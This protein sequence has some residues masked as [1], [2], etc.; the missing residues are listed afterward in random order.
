[1]EY[2]SVYHDKDACKNVIQER[3]EHT[4]MVIKKRKLISIAN[5]I[6]D[7]SDIKRSA[8]KLLKAF[9]IDASK[10]YVPIVEILN[11][12]GIKVYK[13]EMTDKQLS[14]YISVDPEYYDEYG[15]AKIACVNSNDKLGHMRFALAHELAHYIYDFDKQRDTKFYSTYMKDQLKEDDVERRAN[16]FAANLLMPAEVFI[17]KKQE[18]DNQT[19]NDRAETI[20]KLASHFGVLSQAIEKRYQ[21]LGLG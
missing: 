13:Q 5:N 2:I 20:V 3:N 21:E 4:I 10:E 11:A 19:K 16:E 12:F 15:T 8:E 14:A 17:S 9:N 6:R 1:M 7:N 18:F